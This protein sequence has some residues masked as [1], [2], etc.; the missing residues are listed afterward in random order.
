MANLR[1]KYEQAKREYLLNFNAEI[2]V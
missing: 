1:S 2:I